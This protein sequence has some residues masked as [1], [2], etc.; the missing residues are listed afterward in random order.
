MTS[1]KILGSIIINI[2]LLLSS[3]VFP[4]RGWFS[5]NRVAIG[6]SL[7]STYF[8]NDSIGYT[9][10]DKGFVL[11]SSDYGNSWAALSL[12]TSSLNDIFFINGV[13][14]IAGN[15]GKIF[16][17]IDG[18]N[19]NELTSNTNENLNAIY[20]V[21]TD[22]GY[23]FGDAT[24]ILKTTN[25]GASWTNSNLIYNLSITDGAFPTPDFGLCTTSDGVLI[26]SSDFGN[27]WQYYAF[28]S[29]NAFYSIFFASDSIGYITGFEYDLGFILKTTDRGNSF[30]P[31]YPETFANINS[32]YFINPEYGYIVGDG[33]FISKTLDGG[34]NWTTEYNESFKN[35]YSVFF[36]DSLNGY[37]VGADSTILKTTNGG[38]T[39]LLKGSGFSSQLWS[40]YFPTSETGYA[41]GTDGVV[42]KITNDEIS[43]IYRETSNYNLF[44]FVYFLDTLN[45]FTGGDNGKFYTT[46][47]GGQSWVLS[48]Y[49]PQGVVAMSS[50]DFYQNQI[51]IVSA[52]NKMLK[53]VDAGLNW[54][55]INSNTSTWDVAF[56]SDQIIISV[57]TNG[58]VY[59]STDGGTNWI[60]KNSGVTRSLRSVDFLDDNIGFS[61]GWY[62]TIIKTTDAG[63]S[64]SIMNLNTTETLWKIYFIDHNKGYI[65][66]SN[67]II[68]NTTDSGNNWSI[69]NSNTNEDLNDI[70]FV[71]D[72]T[73]YVVGNSGTFLKTISGGI[74]GIEKVTEKPKK[75]LLFQNYP[76][77]FNPTTTIKYQVPKASHITITV[78]DVLG[79]EVA[80]LVNEFKKA[81]IYSVNLD[82]SKLASGVYFYRIKAGE[83]IETKKMLL[84]R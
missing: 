2:I 10:S 38:D 31:L 82:A 81:G 46:T 23:A 9:V 60:P 29:S 68:Y 74:V 67:G 1:G 55:I 73:G 47:D 15:E 37:A 39:W 40:V 24:T 32:A 70:Y 36:T 19:W 4:Q 48:D 25:G 52:G 59:K 22:T 44:S 78:Y 69:Q 61:V 8:I 11:K 12:T 5:I 57:G 21:D 53:T 41:V 62:G 79:K 83:W 56:L 71:D 27:T 64:W 16:K 54:N 33:G 3:E 14:F 76:N 58:K 84:L 63:E 65:I 72:T 35:L 7:N 6:N 34:L 51:G 77:P 18:I 43:L 80:T 20:F 17:T 30:Q 49:R 75:F 66:G 45:G 50:I 13:G 42:Y 26:R 28:P